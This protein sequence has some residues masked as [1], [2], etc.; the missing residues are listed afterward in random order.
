MRRCKY[1]FFES[2]LTDHTCPRCEML[3]DTVEEINESTYQ[4]EISQEGE[5][6]SVVK[7]YSREIIEIFASLG[8]AEAWINDMEEPF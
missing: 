5:L 1:C 2:W 4:Y 7:K 8:E 3:L 6:Y